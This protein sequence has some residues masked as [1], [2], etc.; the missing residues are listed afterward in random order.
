[1]DGNMSDFS[2]T[3]FAAEL[4]EVKEPDLPMLVKL[5]SHVRTSIVKYFRLRDTMLDTAEHAANL[6][7]L[8]ARKSQPMASLC[9]QGCGGIPAALHLRWMLIWREITYKC[10]S[11]IFAALSCLLIWSELTIAHNSIS[12]WA[13]SYRAAKDSDMSVQI[14]TLIPLTYLCSCAFFSLFRLQLFDYYHMDSKRR[15]GNVSLLFNGTYILRIFGPIGANF[16]ALVGVDKDT[17]AF[18]KVIGNISVVPALGDG[19]NTYL[20]I[21]ISIFALCVLFN[22]YHRILRF[23]GIEVFTYWSANDEDRLEEGKRLV[24]AN[25]SAVR[26]ESADNFL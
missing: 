5:N 3:D 17:I 9:S 19:F 26:D 13:V 2:E 11:V 10:L 25:S 23:L 7:L 16:V 15:T 18:Q 6:Q 1:M 21:L 24:D 14:A 22:V 12:P 4:R 8:V 20:P